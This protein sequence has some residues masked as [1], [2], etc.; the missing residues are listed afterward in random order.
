MRPVLRRT[1]DCSVS[2]FVDWRALAALGQTCRMWRDAVADPLLWA[3]LTEHD[4][5]SVAAGRQLQLLR[6]FPRTTRLQLGGLSDPSLVTSM[7]RLLPELVHLEITM[8]PGPPTPGVAGIITADGLGAVAQGLPG[9]LSLRMAGPP[10]G[11]VYTGVGGEEV[12]A[13]LASLPRLRRFSV[14]GVVQ[15]FAS[16]PPTPV[17]DRL[18]EVPVEDQPQPLPLRRLE[19]GATV[20]DE[21][22]LTAVAA[23]FPGLFELAVV[24]LRPGSATVVGAHLD[25]CRQLTRLTLSSCFGLA[26]CDV[27]S[28]KTLESLQLLRCTALTELVAHEMPALSVL[29]VEGCGNLETLAVGG[30][31]LKALE[32]ATAPRL[33][34]LSVECTGLESLSLCGCSALGRGGITRLL[35]APGDRSPLPALRSLDISGCRGLGAEAIEALVTSLCRGG[36]VLPS[37]GL[38]AEPERERATAPAGGGTAGGVTELFAGGLRERCLQLASRSVERLV[39]VSLPFTT[40]LM[41]ALPAVTSLELSGTARELDVGAVLRP[42]RA[43][44]ELT[45]VEVPSLECSLTHELREHEHLR[46]VR[47][48]RCGLTS[49]QLEGQRSIEQLLLLSCERLAKVRIADC[50]ALLGLALDWSPVRHLQVRCAALSTLRTVGCRF[51]TCCI[52]SNTIGSLRGLSVAWSSSGAAASL[53]C[54]VLTELS[55]EK[56]PHLDGAALALLLGGC[57]ALSSLLVAACDRLETVAVPPTVTELRLRTLKHLR[58]FACA[59]DSLRVLLVEDVRFPDQS[60]VTALLTQYSDSL[61]ELTLRG[62]GGEAGLVITLPNLVGLAIER[63]SKLASLTVACPRLERVRLQSCPVLRTLAARTKPLGELQLDQPGP[64]ASVRHLELTA[65]GMPPATMLGRAFPALETLHVALGESGS[66]GAAVLPD[67]L[68]ELTA[69]LLQLRHARIIRGVASVG[70]DAG[71]SGPRQVAI[72]R[73]PALDVKNC[74]PVNVRHTSGQSFRVFVQTDATVADLKRGLEGRTGVPR[75]AQQLVFGGSLLRDA[76]R[77]STAAIAADSSVTLVSPMPVSNARKLPVALF[78]L[79]GC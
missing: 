14:L 8:P 4:L 15:Q 61:Q 44:A 26:K 6:K 35:T 31:A 60:S 65:P 67:Y 72:T 13:L 19:V 57:P 58:S 9:L 54:T 62:L 43:L 23:A 55:L 70:Y 33:R 63:C 29:T 50:N 17:P 16:P 46:S 36:L 11:F 59:A 3:Q 56:C 76:L 18:S 5:R 45:L 47:I 32:L 75:T 1:H 68:E 21:A 66:A 22:G 37:L 12:A 24:A 2:A 28:I 10:A 71:P 53:D 25:G 74:A 20:L 34:E 73:A 51:D 42:L 77:L 52:A 40:D 78:E 39:L 7:Q 41:L 49:C 48:E 27:S 38:A 30:A 64:I 69:N 79:H